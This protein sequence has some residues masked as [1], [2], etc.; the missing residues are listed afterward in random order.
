MPASAARAAATA[1]EVHLS[2]S[3]FVIALGVALWVLPEP[4]AQITRSN[5]SNGEAR[6][7]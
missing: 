7:G 3:I 4:S 2:R 5:L 6:H 1:I